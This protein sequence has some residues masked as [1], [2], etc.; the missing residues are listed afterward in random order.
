MA[1]TDVQWKLTHDL[2]LERGPSSPAWIPD[3]WLPSAPWPMIE[4]DAH[5]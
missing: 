3:G 1:L 2:D 4:V 5:V